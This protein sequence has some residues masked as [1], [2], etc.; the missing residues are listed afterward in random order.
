M[1]M[2]KNTL[3][4]VLKVGYRGGFSLPNSKRVKYLYGKALRAFYFNWKAWIRHKENLF[5]MTQEIPKPTAYIFEALQ[6]AVF[7]ARIA[8]EYYGAQP[9]KAFEL[10]MDAVASVNEL[11]DPEKGIV[12]LV[13]LAERYNDTE[14]LIL[15]KNMVV[16]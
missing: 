1:G 2:S 11:I 9:K 6:K 8:K 15:D 5:V 16:S 4:L 12:S 13:E 10:I 14:P 3:Y 7:V